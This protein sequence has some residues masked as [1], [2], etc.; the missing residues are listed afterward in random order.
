MTNLR[1]TTKSR[2]DVGLVLENQ[3]LSRMTKLCLLYC[4]QVTL[5]HLSNKAR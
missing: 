3:N 1:M 2:F 4:L 5:F